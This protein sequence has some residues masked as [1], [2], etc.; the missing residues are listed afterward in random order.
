[1]LEESI[2]T[3][4]MAFIPLCSN[5]WSIFVLREYVEADG[6]ELLF[7]LGSKIK[8]GDVFLLFLLYL[9]NV[10]IFL[11][12]YVI[13]FPCLKL[14]ALWLV[15]ICWF[16]FSVSYCFIFLS[17][18]ATITFAIGL[19]YIFINTIFAWQEPM[20][21]FYGSAKGYV[22]AGEF[23]WV[24]FPMIIVGGICTALGILANRRYQKYI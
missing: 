24:Y 22:F 18:S 16:L 7:M 10:C 3:C 19:I 4:A 8:Y 9:I 13:T 17:G 2:R 12:I 5:W 6:N 14:M 21:L 20:L 1:M 11:V 23:K 15:I